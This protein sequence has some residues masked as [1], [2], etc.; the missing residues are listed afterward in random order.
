WLQ[1]ALGDALHA[2]LCAAGYNLRWLMR[3]MV[4]LGLRADFLRPLLL[5]LLA[6]TAE[7]VSA[8]APRWPM[9]APRFAAAG[10][11]RGPGG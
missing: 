1:G 6:A 5:W 4:R 2:V 10:W 3:A 8:D 9:I 7:N 11:D